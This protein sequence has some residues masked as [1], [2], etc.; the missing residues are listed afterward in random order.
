MYE[1]LIRR[2]REGQTYDLS[3]GDLHDMSSVMDEAADAIETLQAS[4]A[5]CIGDCFLIGGE[6]IAEN[7]SCPVH[8]LRAKNRY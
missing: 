3:S 6:W 8:G 1:D 4:E 7:P 5:T 2:L